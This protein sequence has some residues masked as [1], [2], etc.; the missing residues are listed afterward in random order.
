LGSHFASR[1]SASILRAINLPELIVERLED[2]ESLAVELAKNPEK[3]SE[4]RQKVW[5]NRLNTPLF[6][7]PR[8]VKNLEKAY[9]EMWRIFLAGE[10]PHQIDVVDSQGNFSKR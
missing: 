8:F 6:D 2:Y 5:K 3:L 1:V 9:N 10:N 4:V 7:T